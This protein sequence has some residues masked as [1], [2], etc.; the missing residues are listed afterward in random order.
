M[1]SRSL[2]ETLVFKSILVHLAPSA[3]RALQKVLSLLL[4]DQVRVSCLT[5][6]AKPEKA[7]ETG[8]RS[9]SPCLFITETSVFAKMPAELKRLILGELDGPARTLSL[10]ILD[11]R[12]NGLTGGVHRLSLVQLLR[13]VTGTS[14]V[15]LNINSVLQPHRRALIKMLTHDFPPMIK[16]NKDYFEELYALSI[17]WLPRIFGIGEV[18]TREARERFKSEIQEAIAAKNDALLA[19]LIKRISSLLDDDMCLILRDGSDGA[20]SYFEIFK[21]NTGRLIRTIRSSM[22]GLTDVG[23][24]QTRSFS[25]EAALN[26]WLCW[27]VWRFLGFDEEHEILF[28]NTFYKETF[29]YIALNVRRAGC[30]IREDLRGIYH[31]ENEED[32]VSELENALHRVTERFQSLSD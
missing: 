3:G 30:R 21:E 29:Y 15:I 26:F 8:C 24:L 7:I 9:G 10:I 13:I 23:P 25:A 31:K 14:P 28:N 20:D 4:T 2:P 27:W 5:E 18:W 19:S 1:S 17:D 12:D 6:E 32:V 16:V 22:T 11:R